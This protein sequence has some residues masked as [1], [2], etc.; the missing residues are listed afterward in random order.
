MATYNR[1]AFIMESVKSLL[2]QTYQNWEL[3]IVDDGSDDNT[4]ELITQI[5]DDRI[6]FY[7]AGRIGVGGKI[8]NIGLEKTNGE[9]VAFIDSD[10]LWAATK[11]EKQVA[12]LQQY[13]DAGFCLTG[14][15]NFRQPGFPASFFYKQREGTRHDNF[16][17]SFFQSGIAIFTQTLLLKKQC[18]AVSGHFHDSKSFVEGDFD[19][20]A[21]LARDFKGVILYE[22]LM[23][24]RLHDAN[25][26]TL[27]WEKS[28]EDGIT[29]ISTYLYDKKLPPNTV[30]NI[31]FLSHI[32]F[33]EECL[34]NKKRR[35]AIKSFFKAWANKPFSIVPLKKTGKAIWYYMN[36]K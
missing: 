8:K 27:N 25:H 4:E 23:Y 17:L 22:P 31:L 34:A 7:K 1:A 10:D 26:T 12:A 35:K 13:T 5:K 20:M 19:F 21:R 9:L 15:Y 33:G 11:L 3:I 36:N 30:S 2:Q 18:L 6:L 24:R 29:A 28:H 32:H 16:F 14:G